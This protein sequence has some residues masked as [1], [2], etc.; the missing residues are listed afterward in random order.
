M[1]GVEDGM[2]RDVT[3]EAAWGRFPLGAGMTGSGGGMTGNG[4]GMTGS[5]GRE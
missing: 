1:E 2:G 4:G 3:L 5:E